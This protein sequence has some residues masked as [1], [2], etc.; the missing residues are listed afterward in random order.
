MIMRINRCVVCGAETKVKA[1]GRVR[2]YCS[3]R[4]RVR[5]QR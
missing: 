5:S 3:D 4:C 1:V 2:L